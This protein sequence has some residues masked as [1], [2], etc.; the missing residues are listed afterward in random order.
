MAVFNWATNLRAVGRQ[1]EGYEHD[2]GKHQ[3]L[4][5]SKHSSNVYAGIL[6]QCLLLPKDLLDPSGLLV[7]YVKKLKLLHT[8]SGLIAGE[9]LLW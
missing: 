3:N 5:R 2:A 4:A 9:C 6:P 7:I 8:N 1:Q